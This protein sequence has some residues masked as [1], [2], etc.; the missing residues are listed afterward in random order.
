MKYIAPLHYTPEE[1]VNLTAVKVGMRLEVHMR[2]GKHAG[3]EFY[4]TVCKISDD[5]LHDSCFELNK[6]DLIKGMAELRNRDFTPSLKSTLEAALD[7]KA[8]RQD[9]I[10][11]IDAELVAMEN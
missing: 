2:T 1:T 7:G 10:N 9:V 11:A 8:T 3:R 6:A 4:F 5:R